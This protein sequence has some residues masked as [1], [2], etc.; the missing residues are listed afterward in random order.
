[1]GAICGGF[2][3]GWLADKYGRVPALIGVNIMGFL[4]GLGSIFCKNFWQFSACRFI[5]G[6]AFDNTFILM[7]IIVLE[8]IGPKWRTFV[9]NMS[10]GIFYSLGSMAMP[11]TAYYVADWK[12]FSLV[13]TIP[14][15]T[16]IF[17][18]WFIPESARYAFFLKIAIIVFKICKQRSC[19]FQM[20]RDQ[21]R[22]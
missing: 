6:F 19:N 17:V 9:A 10:Y 20:A 8:Y 16:V 1:M 12:I 11:W 7:Y 21:R 14:L 18:P 22:N 5:M 4:G 2:L 15:L 13:T 3:F